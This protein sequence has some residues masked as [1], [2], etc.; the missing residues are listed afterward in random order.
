MYIHAPKDIQADM[1]AT[2]KD[3]APSYATVKRWAMQFK[4]D[5]D[6]CGQP[7][8]APTVENI[9]RAQS[10][11]PEVMKLFSCSTQQSIKF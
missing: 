6:R 11:G 2:L 3:T 4:M 7:P 9:A 8:T 10:P 1:V 5:N